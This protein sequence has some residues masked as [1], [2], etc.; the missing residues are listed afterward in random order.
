M[1][2][3]WTPIINDLEKRGITNYHITPANGCTMV[4]YSRVVAYYYVVD[5]EITE[6]VYD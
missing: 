2:D 6:V 5:G 3:D 1:T 4:C